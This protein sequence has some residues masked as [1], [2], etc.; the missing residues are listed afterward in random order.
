MPEFSGRL[1]PVGRVAV[2]VSR[3]NELVTSRLLAG[4]RDCC[5]QAGIAPADMDVLWVPGAFEL[6]VAADAA[7]RTGRY[8]CAVALGVVV[9]GDTP[10]FE[11]VAGAA[12]RGLGEVART[13][14]V[15]V[16]FGLLTVETLEQALARSGGDAGNK[17]FEAT[18]A[19]LRTADLLGLV[20]RDGA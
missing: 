20:A 11:F 6:P 17:G 3:Y 12:S 4:A 7:I 10:H 8:A 18:D 13:H 15:P 19:A 1:R 2:I 14:G 5:A 16:G 9:R